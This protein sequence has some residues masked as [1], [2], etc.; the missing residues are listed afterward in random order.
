MQRLYQG[1]YMPLFF[2]LQNYIHR[3]KQPQTNKM[4]KCIADKWLPP[5]FFSCKKGLVT[6][7]IGLQLRDCCPGTLLSGKWNS[8]FS[9]EIHKQGESVETPPGFLLSSLYVFV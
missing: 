5:Y 1:S 3:I 4:T 6:N 7:H 9:A 8:S 2:S